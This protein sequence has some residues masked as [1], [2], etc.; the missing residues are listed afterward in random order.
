M[1]ARCRASYRSLLSFKAIAVLV[2]LSASPCAAQSFTEFAVPSAD[3]GPIG[4][5]TGPDSN[6]WFTERTANKIGRLTPAGVFTEFPLP[7]NGQ[8]LSSQP[9]VILHGPDGALWFT[10]SAASRVGRI[11]TDGVTTF[12]PTP[13]GQ[14]GTEGL[15]VG[16]DGNIWFTEIAANKIGRLLV[17]GTHTITEFP[18]PTP[19]SRPARITTGPDGNLWFTESQTTP[20]A[21]KIGRITTAGAITELPIPTANG[22]PWGIIGSAVGGGSIV[23]TERAASKIAQMDLNGQVVLEL[24]TPTAASDP[25]RVVNGPDRHVWFAEQ[26][27]NNIA[28]IDSHGA[29]TE[30]PV[31]TTG[32]GPSGMTVGPDGALW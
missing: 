14:S 32:S 28:R 5:V 17:G 4:I 9:T 23:F 31:P 25:V 22:Q 3:S 8:G 11:T 12:F 18:I 24:P 1:I 16:P 21:G 29:I 7:V 19:N 13:T 10:M 15:A 27:G 30:C 6:L 26:N 20:P 2:L